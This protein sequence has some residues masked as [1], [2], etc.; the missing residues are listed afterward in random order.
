MAHGSIPHSKSERP[1]QPGPFTISRSDDDGIHK[2]RKVRVW[3]RF[4]ALIT[5][6]A[7]D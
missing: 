7:V 2:E 6:A 5:H 1:V 4:D 3:L